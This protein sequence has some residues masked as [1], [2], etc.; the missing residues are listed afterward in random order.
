MLESERYQ[1]L[2]DQY[3]TQA[4][5]WFAGMP[6]GLLALL[7]SEGRGDL[8]A[9]WKTVFYEGAA[10][11]LSVS[12]ALTV[13]RFRIV[14]GIYDLLV[15]REKLKENP[16]KNSLD[17]DHPGKVEAVRKPDEKLNQRLQDLSLVFLALGALSAMLLWLV[18]FSK[19]VECPSNDEQVKSSSAEI[20]E[21][22]KNREKPRVGFPEGSISGGTR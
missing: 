8:W 11:C 5:F 2:A 20:E 13:G 1:Q 4:N 10:I 19:S 7:I 17:H 16:T 3:R 22:L 18:P 12:C 9:P 6:F 14:P 21:W 15:K